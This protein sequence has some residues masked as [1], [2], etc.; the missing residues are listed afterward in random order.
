MYQ[1]PKQLVVTAVKAH[2]QMS[3]VHR[4]TA[5]CWIHSA[6]EVVS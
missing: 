5:L 2:T 6:P 3:G 1:T 4:E